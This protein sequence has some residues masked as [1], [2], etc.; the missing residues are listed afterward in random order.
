MP[1]N[2]QVKRLM[3]SEIKFDK[4]L[5]YYDS[6]PFTGIGMTMWNEKQITPEASFKSGRIDGS[7]RQ[8]HENGKLQLQSYWKEG[9]GNGELK[10]YDEN[11]QLLA[12]G[13]FKDGRMD[14]LWKKYYQSGQVQSET[15]YKNGMIEGV[16]REYDEKGKLR[17]VI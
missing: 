13:I 7:V 15:T 17:V 4:G 5:F 14:G 1:G 9:K 3:D 8:F 2:S 12:E 6:V 11:G 10:E 16:V